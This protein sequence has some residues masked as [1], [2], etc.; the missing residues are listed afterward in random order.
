MNE[1]HYKL[2]TMPGKE[3]MLPPTN[4]SVHQNMEGVNYTLYL[5]EHTLEV[6]FN[7][8]S[9]SCRT[10]DGNLKMVCSVWC[11]C[12]KFIIRFIGIY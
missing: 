8:P 4:D 1:L 9:P 12:S 11:I 5:W 2:F 6:D 10:W 7:I 3:K